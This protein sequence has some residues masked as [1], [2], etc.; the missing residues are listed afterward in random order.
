MLAVNRTILCVALMLAAVLPS[1]AVRQKPKKPSEV[2]V[3]DAATAIAIGRTT[4]IKVYGKRQIDYEEPLNA[5]LDNGVWSVYGTLC[6][7]DREGKRTC[8][9]GKCVGGVVT[10]KIR[11]GDGKILS[12]GHTA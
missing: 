3:P 7:P 11:Q 5:S 12:I 8:E 6:C 2:R 1:C 9:T 4:A 10:V